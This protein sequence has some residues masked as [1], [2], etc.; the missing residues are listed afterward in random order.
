MYPSAAPAHDPL[1]YGMGFPP[2]QQQFQPH[3][4]APPPHFPPMGADGF[5]DSFNANTNDQWGR[6]PSH[7]PTMPAV[8]PSQSQTPSIP[9]QQQQQQQ[10]SVVIND[11]GGV[12]ETG[13]S[14]P[15]PRTSV[16]WGGPSGVRNNSN[17]KDIHVYTFIRLI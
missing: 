17:M 8:P 16:A 4:P 6:H 7:P 2:N 1:P 5:H 9:A 3:Y 12:N 15:A 11:V 14:S 10:P 13:G